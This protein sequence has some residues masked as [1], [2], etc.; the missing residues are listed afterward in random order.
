MKMIL[1][2]VGVAGVVGLTAAGCCTAAQG[3]ERPGE[4]ARAC[5]PGTGGRGG[6]GAGVDRLC[7]VDH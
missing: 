3:W 6:E 5:E 2:M 7:T 1:A 4:R